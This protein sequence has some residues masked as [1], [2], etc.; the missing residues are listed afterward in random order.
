MKT[1]MKGSR[2]VSRGNIFKIFIIFYLV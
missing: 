1:R 2:V